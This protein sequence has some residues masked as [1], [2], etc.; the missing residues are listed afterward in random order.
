[1]G[2]RRG[3]KVRAVDAIDADHVFQHRGA[4]VGRLPVQQHA[5]GLDARERDER[6]EGHFEAEHLHELLDGLRED[7]VGAEG[8]PGRAC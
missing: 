1:M 5:V 3:D 8:D 7:L 2:A 6:R 4:L